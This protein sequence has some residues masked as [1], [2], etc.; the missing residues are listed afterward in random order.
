MAA[1]FL[2]DGSMLRLRSSVQVGDGLG[3]TGVGC[4]D[5]SD[6]EMGLDLHLGL[7][8]AGA[9]NFPAAVNSKQ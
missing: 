4:G 3:G 8:P 6:D 9:R 1:A 5:D 7:A 2:A